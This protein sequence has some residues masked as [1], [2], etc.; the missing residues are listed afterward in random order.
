VGWSAPRLT[1]RWS[2]RWP[3]LR[4]APGGAIDPKASTSSAKYPVLTAGAALGTRS[5][6]CSLYA[7]CVL[8][9]VIRFRSLLTLARPGGSFD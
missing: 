8:M 2:P 1:E 6:D 9:V 5:F 7:S 4:G 3:S